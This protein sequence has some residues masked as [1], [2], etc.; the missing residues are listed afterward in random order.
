[1]KSRSDVFRSLENYKSIHQ[2]T[3][4]NKGVLGEFN[5]AKTLTRAKKILFGVSNANKRKKKN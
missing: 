4:K 1:M 2:K 3:A 5:A